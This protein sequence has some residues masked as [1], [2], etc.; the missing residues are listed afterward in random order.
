MNKCT[1]K[2]N[3][4][5]IDGRLTTILKTTDFNGYEIYKHEIQNFIHWKLFPL[6]TEHVKSIEN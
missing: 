1:N 4:L 6:H 5:F 2:P 3:S